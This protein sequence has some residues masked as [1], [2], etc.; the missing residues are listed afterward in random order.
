MYILTSKFCIMKCIQSA[1]KS[2]LLQHVKQ[3]ID[4][5][6]ERLISHSGFPARWLERRHAWLGLYKNVTGWTK[7]IIGTRY[8]FLRGRWRTTG[9]NY[10]PPR[11]SMLAGTQS[12]PFLPLHSQR[13]RR[14]LTRPASQM[15][16]NARAP[17]PVIPNRG[18]AVPWG[19]ANTSQ[20]YHEMQK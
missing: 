15:R 12:H 20:G 17:K 10:F 3:Y 5:D 14:P 9:A 8:E 16:G 19:T 4:A 2:D 6:T 7:Q 11:H 1:D 18:S 13:L